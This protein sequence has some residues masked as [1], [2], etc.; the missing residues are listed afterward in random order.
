MIIK[1]YSSTADPMSNMTIITAIS[2]AI[3]TFQTPIDV[4]GAY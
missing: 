3:R 4:G 2:K 1:T